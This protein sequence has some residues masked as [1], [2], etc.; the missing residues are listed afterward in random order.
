MI[1]ISPRDMLVAMAFGFTISAILY[2]AAIGSERSPEIAKDRQ[3]VI[4]WK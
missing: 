4:A 1:T 3:E 2:G